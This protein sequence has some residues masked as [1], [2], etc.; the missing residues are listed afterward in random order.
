MKW[1]KKNSHRW[2]LRHEQTT[3]SFITLTNCILKTIIDI[4]YKSAIPLMI[5]ILLYTVFLWSKVLLKSTKVKKSQYI[6]TFFYR[7]RFV[8]LPT[9][10]ISHNNSRLGMLRVFLERGHMAFSVL[11]KS[12]SSRLHHCHKWLHTLKPH[13]QKH[14][15]QDLPRQEA[16]KGTAIAH[17]DISLLPKQ[18]GSTK[19]I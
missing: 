13:C 14:T 8:L 1:A 3:L 9:V 15:H 17:Y 6:K 19:L 7:N 18:P 4:N 2:S 16:L 10:T 5:I 11:K 12:Q